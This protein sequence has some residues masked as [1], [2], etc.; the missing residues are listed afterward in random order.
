[1]KT[2]KSGSDCIRARRCTD[3]NGQN[4]IHQQRSSGEESG[5]NTQIAFGYDI[6]ATALR[7][8][9]DGLTVG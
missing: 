5:W 9:K 7:I 1:M 3:R 4:I 6:R 8:S 2:W